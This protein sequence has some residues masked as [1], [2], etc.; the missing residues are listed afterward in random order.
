ME[1]TE[2]EEIMRLVLL[3][4][5]LSVCLSVY[6]ITAQATTPDITLTSLPC[7]EAALLSASPFGK[8][9]GALL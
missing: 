3:S 2:L 6:T 4:V 7:I 5:C 8:N 1:R 9:G